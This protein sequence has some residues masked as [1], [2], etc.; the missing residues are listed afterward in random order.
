MNYDIH[1][2][3]NPLDKNDLYEGRTVCFNNVQTNPNNIGILLADRGFSADIIWKAT[4]NNVVYHFYVDGVCFEDNTKRLYGVE[5][6]VNLDVNTN[7]S[8]TRGEGESAT[9]TTL[10]SITPKD[11]FA[12]YALE[13]LINTIP[14]PL[15]MDDSTILSLAI[16]AYKISQAM[17]YIGTLARGA[18]AIPSGGST[19]P[20]NVD[21]N[22]L[23]NDVAKILYN[24]NEN[25]KVIKNQQHIQYTD[26]LKIASFEQPLC[27]DNPEDEQHNVDK[28]QIEGAGGGGGGGEVTPPANMVTTDTAQNITGQKTF[29]SERVYFNNIPTEIISDFNSPASYFGENSCIYNHYSVTTDLDTQE[30]TIDEE[31]LVIKGQD[32]IEFRGASNSALIM[33]LTPNGRVT[34]TGGFVNAIHN[35]SDSILIGDGNVADFRD[36]LNELQSLL[37]VRIAKVLN[38]SVYEFNVIKPF[39]SSMGEGYYYVSGNLNWS[40][41]KSGA[42]IS[43]NITGVIFQI[44]DDPVSPIVNIIG[45]ELIN[46]EQEAVNCY[47]IYNENTGNIELKLSNPCLDDVG[48]SVDSDAIIDTIINILS[49]SYSFASVRGYFRIIN[50]TV[51]IDGFITQ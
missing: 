19:D 32:K 20:V 43:R 24:L 45:G 50:T 33:S 23:S 49:T 15:A 2:T 28:F 7:N 17:L 6:N 51:T 22:N 5:T 30:S 21:S 4:I 16:K 12:M 44:L 48:S 29:K 41:I 34:A 9:T 47:R 35:N 42:T 18:D 40:I 1:P 37:N 10:S 36:L 46:S 13:A 39:I 3:Q 14:H 11:E 27:V 26:G 25:I 31:T 8:I 38:G